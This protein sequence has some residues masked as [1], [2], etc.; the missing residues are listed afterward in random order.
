MD[1][2]AVSLACEF[3]ARASVEAPT[4][5]ARLA[6]VSPTGFSGKRRHFGP[7]GGHRGLAWLHR[8]VSHPAWA[9]GLFD[10]LT[11]PRV[12]RYFLKRTWGAP[13]IDEALW[14]YCVQTARH[15]GARHAPLYFLAAHLFSADVNAVYEALECPVWMSMATRGDFTDYRGCDT[16]Q[17]RSNWRIHRVEG[18][19]LPFFE[20]LNHFARLLDPFWNTPVQVV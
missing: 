4:S 10:L 7:A 16:V 15:S 12:V 13:L 8:A 20:D 1:V 19:A 9:Q 2:L 18:G 17:G 6:L 14:R 3:A 5:I 11:R